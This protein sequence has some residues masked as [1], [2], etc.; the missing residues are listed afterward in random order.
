MSYFLG[1]I[2][3][4]RM[5]WLSL[6]IML[7]IVIAQYI[8]MFVTTK[9][10]NDAGI[11]KVSP[12]L[13][14]ILYFNRLSFYSE[15]YLLIFPML[16]AMAVAGIYRIDKNYGFIYPVISKMGT[17]YYFKLLYFINFIVSFFIISVPL[18]FNFYLY[19]MTY[20][21]VAPHPILN[22]MASTVSP[23]AQFHIVYYKYPTLYFLM[24]VFLNGLYGAVFSSLALS[25]SF[26]IKRVYF[27][28]LVPF[29]LHIFWLGIGKG[30]LN[31]KDYLIKDFGF[32][33]LQIFLSVLL[34][35]WF[36]S[37]VLY[38]RGSRKH[39]LL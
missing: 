15:F 26:F 17:C 35:I 25:V 24:Y 34:C 7:V 6:F 1:R 20:P 18:L 23:T 29:I 37:V 22:Y 33:E 36:C 32:F 39:V 8:A 4:G 13:S 21:T 31:L 19:V 3:K 14:N 38:L 2:L 10:F 9:G 12:Y 5:F 30:I 28:Y 11:I 16:S 27:I